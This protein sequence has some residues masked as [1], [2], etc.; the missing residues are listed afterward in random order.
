MCISMSAVHPKHIIPLYHNLDI[1][2]DHNKTEGT[3]LGPNTSIPLN[4]LHSL[5]SCQLCIS[6]SGLLYL[7]CGVLSI[8]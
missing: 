1:G 6:V 4:Y 3:R 5:S 7:L 2:R 8:N